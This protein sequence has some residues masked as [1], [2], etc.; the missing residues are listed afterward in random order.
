MIF[1]SHHPNFPHETLPHIIEVSQ[2]RVKLNKWSERNYSGVFVPIYSKWRLLGDNA[3][4][5]NRTVL[6]HT[7]KTTGSKPDE[8]LVRLDR[9]QSSL[10]PFI[11]LTKYANVTGFS[12]HR[13]SK[14]LLNYSW[15]S[16]SRKKR[17]ENKN[18]SHRY[19]LS[20]S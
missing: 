5:S 18:C 20:I 13:L 7:Q 16:A 12:T 15:N 4:S 10:N 3:T 6:R 8:R 2:V 1:K 14:T 19:G 17:A 9:H 11:T